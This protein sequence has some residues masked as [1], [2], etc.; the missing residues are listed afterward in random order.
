MLKYEIFHTKA[1]LPQDDDRLKKGLTLKIIEM[2]KVRAPV[3]LF[4]VENCL[5]QSE[6]SYSITFALPSGDLHCIGVSE[7]VF[8]QIAAEFKEVE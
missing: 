6:Y 5:S 2:E 7:Y 8:D 3:P 1:A 4:P